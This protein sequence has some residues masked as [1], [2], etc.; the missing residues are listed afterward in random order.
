VRI[1][2]GSGLAHPTLSKGPIVQE[3]MEWAPKWLFF[4]D[5][6]LQVKPQNIYARQCHISWCYILRA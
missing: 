2:D 5:M 1:I 6:D 3:M 4:M